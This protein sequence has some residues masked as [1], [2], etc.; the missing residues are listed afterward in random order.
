MIDRVRWLAYKKAPL[1]VRTQRGR[2][3]F[4]KFY[5]SI[6]GDVF[7]LFCKK[8]A[9]FS[10]RSLSDGS[11]WSNESA[12]PSLFS[13]VS[14]SPDKMSFGVIP[15]A[16]HILRR[17]SKEIPLEPFSTWLMWSLVTS[18]ASASSAWV[19][20]CCRRR[21]DRFCISPRSKR[22]TTCSVFPLVRW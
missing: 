21:I 19:S 17:S 22:S 12:W 3:S 7:F 6:Q 8:C 1:G 18:A 15:S 2:W 4:R 20:P 13:S 5:L 9:I 16:R 11:K 10:I 14:Y